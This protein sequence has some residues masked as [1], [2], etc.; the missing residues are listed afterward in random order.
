MYVCGL[1]ALN[2]DVLCI[3]GVLRR[4]CFFVNW[5]FLKCDI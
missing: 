3:G 5:I 2:M 4:G 1:L